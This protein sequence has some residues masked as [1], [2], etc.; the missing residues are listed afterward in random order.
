MQQL[1]VWWCTLI[2][3]TH[4]PS[5]T[6]AVGVVGGASLLVAVYIAFTLAM[7]VTSLAFSRPT[8]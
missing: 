5:V 3:I 6:V 2:G 7:L 1:V 4:D 8:I